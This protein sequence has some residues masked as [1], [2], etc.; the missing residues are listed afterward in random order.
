MHIKDSPSVQEFPEQHPRVSLGEVAD[1]ASGPLNMQVCLVV[2]RDAIEPCPNYFGSQPS[3]ACTK[4]DSVQ[5]FGGGPMQS[6]T[7]AMFARLPP[8]SPQKRFIWWR[9]RGRDL[10]RPTRPLHCPAPVEVLVSAFVVI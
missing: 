2:D 7:T 8:S 6:G 10:N 4:L 9:L 5:G 3:G 1:E